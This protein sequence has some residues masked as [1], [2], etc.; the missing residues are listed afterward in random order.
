MPRVEYLL[1]CGRRAEIW[2]GSGQ[3]GAAR[4]WNEAESSLTDD[5]Q[6]TLRA[7]E[8]AYEVKRFCSY[9]ILSRRRFHWRAIPAREHRARTPSPAARPPALV[10]MRSEGALLQRGG[11]GVIPSDLRGVLQ[12]SGNYA[13]LDNRR[14]HHWG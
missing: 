13:V 11:R 1:N 6:H 2:E 9:D 12:V 7:D 14:Y 8:K 3:H 10:A 5:T 4:G